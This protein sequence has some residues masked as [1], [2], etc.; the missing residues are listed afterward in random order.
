MEQIDFT[1]FEN[2]VGIFCEVNMLEA[3]LRR[4]LNGLMKVSGDFL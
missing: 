4:Y 3:G 2:Y 1:V